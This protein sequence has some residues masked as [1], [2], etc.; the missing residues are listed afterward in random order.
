M[1]IFDTFFLLLIKILTLQKLLI[2]ILVI[3]TN[4]VLKVLLK[5]GMKL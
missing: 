2:S 5:V 1:I 3:F 4:E